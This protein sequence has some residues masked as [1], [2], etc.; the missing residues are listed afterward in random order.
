MTGAARTR[1]WR[2]RQARG[3][4]TVVQVEVTDNL[5]RKLVS[6]D[7]LSVSREGDGVTVKR[8]GIELAINAMLTK[9]STS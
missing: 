4:R 3:I 6:E 7:W 2:D 9:W 8:E 5:V 1:L